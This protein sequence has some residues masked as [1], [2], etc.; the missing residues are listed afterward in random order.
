MSE[1]P[2]QSLKVALTFGDPDVPDREKRYYKWYFVHALTGF[3][4]GFGMVVTPVHFEEATL[5]LPFAMLPGMVAIRQTVEFLRR[6]DTP[7]RDLGDH[8]TGFVI[9]LVGGAI[10]LQWG[11]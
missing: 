6:N 5:V 11:I 8:L 9:G 7:G 1:N 2:E 4:G 10:L 3:I